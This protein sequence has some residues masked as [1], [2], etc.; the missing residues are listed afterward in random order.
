M[1]C[2][3]H[4]FVRPCC[5]QAFGLEAYGAT[6]AD[7]RRQYR[8]LAALVHPDKCGVAGAAAAFQRLQAAAEALQGAAAAAEGGERRRKRART[9]D[10][11]PAASGDS[12]SCSD[13]G[14]DDDWLPHGGGFPWWEEWDQPGAGAAGG[15]AGSAAGRGVQ[16]GAGVPP[17]AAA[18]AAASDGAVA[19]A[20]QDQ[21]QLQGLPLDALRA[22]V[23]QRQAA[24]LAPPC[25]A[26]GR[27]VPLPQLQARLRCARTTLADRVA[28]EAAAEAAVGGGGFLP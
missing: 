14:G 17:A 3:C 15:A 1:R 23:R 16:Q 12:G 26:S 7:V 25:D 27:R 8:R 2:C 19:E 28:A 20:G 10:G 5:L 22:E 24:L 11:S 13:S 18:T 9:R 21:E 4:A 6:P